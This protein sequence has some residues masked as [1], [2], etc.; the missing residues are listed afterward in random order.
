MPVP[1]CGRYRPAGSRDH[2]R[3]AATHRATTA[4]LRGRSS[5]ACMR[6][7]SNLIS[8]SHSEPSGGWS[9]SFVSCGLIHSGRSGVSAR[10]RPA[11]D[12]AM[13]RRPDSFSRDNEYYREQR[14]NRRQAPKN[15]HLTP[16]G[17][18][19]SSKPSVGEAASGRL[20]APPT[21][22][23]W[24]AKP[25]TKRSDL[26]RIMVD[27]PLSRSAPLRWVA[28]LRRQGCR[29]GWWRWA[30]RTELVENSP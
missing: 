11:T 3:R 23:P 4:H 1:P 19:L 6:Y 13:P 12:L 21:R 9:T 20:A 18:G 22:H 8:C 27:G 25:T 2:C 17:R 29:C 14:D 16:Q 10:G 15:L 30:Y 28:F 26:W 7:P 5:Q 24:L